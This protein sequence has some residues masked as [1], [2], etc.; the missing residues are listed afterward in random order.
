VEQCERQSGRRI[1]SAVVSIAGSHVESQNTRGVTT[2]SNHGHDLT[3]SDLQK[4]LDSAR[5]ISLPPNREVIHVVP[6]SFVL[7]GQDG[8]RNPIGM[9]ASAWKRRPTSSPAPSAPSRT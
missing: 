9:S 2:L 1:S 3:N 4:A 7:D 8:I 5:A 6:R